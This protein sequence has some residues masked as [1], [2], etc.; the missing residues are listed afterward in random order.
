MDKAS[1]EEI[2]LIPINEVDEL[3]RKLSPLEE[4]FR[5]NT[6]RNYSELDY[7]RRKEFQDNFC[8][9]QRKCESMKLYNT[10]C[11]VSNNSNHFLLSNI[12]S[13]FSV[14]QQ[15]R[16]FPS[17][18]HRHTFIEM[19]YV[20][21]GVCKQYIGNDQEELVMNRGEICKLNSNLIHEISYYR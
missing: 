6:V 13:D 1:S 11:V 8:L 10:N 5:D 2:K 12:E 20:Y 4:F 3:L 7:R 9:L 19:I 17:S 16:F 21:D 14:N 18:D 15:V